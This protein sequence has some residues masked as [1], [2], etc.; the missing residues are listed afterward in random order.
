MLNLLRKIDGESKPLVY[1]PLIPVSVKQQYIGNS[2]NELLYGT[3]QGEI[4]IEHVI[5][6][7]NDSEVFRVSTMNIRE[8]I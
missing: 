5:G 2:R 6:N 1:I 8:I 3:V 4:S 7:E